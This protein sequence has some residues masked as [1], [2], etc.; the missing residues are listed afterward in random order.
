M[1]KKKNVFD[2]FKNDKEYQELYKRESAILDIA[3]QVAETRQKQN[4]TQKELGKKIGVPQ[5]TISRIESG[6]SN[7]TLETLLKVT[8]AL[9][10]K[11]TIA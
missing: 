8:T 9:N 5:S 7:V 6:S 3:I 10:K 11:V 1:A 4:L 2:K